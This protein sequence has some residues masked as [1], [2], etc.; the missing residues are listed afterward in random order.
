MNN[1]EQKHSSLFDMT[2][3]DYEKSLREI[4]EKYKHVLAECDLQLTQAVQKEV[5]KIKSSWTWRIG[6]AQVTALVLTKNFL[7]NPV[8]FLLKKQYRW[9]NIFYF[10]NVRSSLRERDDPTLENRGK[11]SGQADVE[12]LSDPEKL[13]VLCVLDTFTRDCFAPEFNLI[14]PTPDHW[15]TRLEGQK[16][17]AVFIESAWQG[18]NRS[19]E[20]LTHNLDGADKIEIVAALVKAAKKRGIKTI[21]WNKEDPVH[22]N[23][24]IDT[25]KLFDFIFTSD[26]G[27]VQKYNEQLGHS[28]TFSLPFA[29]QPEIHNPVT[30]RNQ[31]DKNVCF[32]GSYYNMAYAERKM[33]LDILLKPA[34][35][36]GL[37]IYDRNFGVTGADSEKHRF[38]QIYQPYIKGKL[39][40]PE[41]VRAYKQYKVFL[42]VNT[43]KYSSTMFARRVFELLACGTPVISNYSKGIINL[44]G[45][46][47]VFIAETE[48]DTRRYL[49]RL[50]GDSHFWWKKS[51]AGM[52]TVM[53][54]HTYAERAR[55]IC[56]VTGLPFRKREPVSFLLLSE[57]KSLEDSDFL[58]RMI[59]HQV[60]REYKV[61]LI[62]APALKQPELLKEEIEKRFSFTKITIIDGDEEKRAAKV[63]SAL[64][65]THMAWFHAGHL[66]GKN[67]L[68]DYALA[69]TY[70]KAKILGKKETVSIDQT[71]AIVHPSG[72]FAYRYV[73]E[74]P[75][76]TVVIDKSLCDGIEIPG[77]FRQKDFSLHNRSILS[78]DP[79]NYFENGKNGLP[80]S[81]LEKTG[82]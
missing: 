42:N 52:R 63:I 48:D 56:T 29:A 6:W 60:Y 5:N 71:G 74:V 9:K 41:M 23:A 54:S 18:N 1:S 10:N 53:E 4:R 69:V 64:D 76:A 58:A 28:H 13:N 31:R 49:D 67:Y 61:L 38:P 2:P 72:G 59:R 39:E 27:C 32:A 65:F 82:I 36:Y 35:S 75:S 20:F 24:F 26:S 80:E 22:F 70:S 51:L 44:L 19:W 47:T 3:E 16:I 43:V 12:P 50:L 78:I 79:Y 34:I 77:S 33:D 15:K 66:Y 81:I 37:E 25:A 17:D 62:L 8:R 73:D 46:D 30:G 7:F 11:T 55:E 21:F 57:I 14:C 40:Y 68:R 45:E